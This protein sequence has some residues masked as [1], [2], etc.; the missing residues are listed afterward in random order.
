VAELKTESTYGD[1]PH[2]WKDNQEWRFRRFR[3]SDGVLLMRKGYWWTDADGPFSFLGCSA[4]LWYEDRF[5]CPV[6]AWG[7]PLAGVFVAT[8][9]TLPGVAMG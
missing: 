2:I 8:G 7:E 4:H 3:T 1:S 9:S 5:G 6:D